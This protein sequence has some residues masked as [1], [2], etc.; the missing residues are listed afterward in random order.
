MM[1]SKKDLIHAIVGKIPGK[2]LSPGDVLM[3]LDA[4]AD[5]I[6][7]AMKRG[8]EAPLVGLGKISAKTRPGRIGRNPRTGAS[9]DVPA[10][11][12]I[13]FKPASALKVALN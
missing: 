1:F 3:V 11:V 5:V 12:G 9:V 13:K 6:T 10:S 8:E 4:H 7:E 2:K